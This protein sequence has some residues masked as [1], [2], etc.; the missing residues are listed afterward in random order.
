LHGPGSQSDALNDLLLQESA[1]R[2]P[3][4]QGQ[5]RLSGASIER[6]T[7]CIWGVP[8]PRYTR[9]SKNIMIANM[10]YRADIG[11][12]WVEDSDKLHNWGYLR[13]L[14]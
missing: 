3:D 13:S 14:V 6:F 8:R 9:A 2:M 5:H 4:E 12:R 1:I 11:D 10:Y 7:D